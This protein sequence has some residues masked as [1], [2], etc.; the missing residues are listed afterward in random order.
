M[1]PLRYY[2][3]FGE[4]GEKGG[5]RTHIEGPGDGLTLCG[6]DI[7]GDPLVHKKPPVEIAKP[8]R[9]TCGHCL[10]VIAYVQAHLADRR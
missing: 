5:V 7:I 10:Q 1:P 6:F 8:K 4:P 2:R 9:I 3:T